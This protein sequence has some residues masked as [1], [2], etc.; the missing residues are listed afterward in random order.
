M[1]KTL[2][3]IFKKSIATIVCTAVGIAAASAAVYAADIGGTIYTGLSKGAA[4]IDVKAYHMTPQA[5]MDEFFKVVDDNP[6]L[7]YVNSHVD[8]KYDMKSGECIELVCSYTTTDVKGTRAKFDAE[9]NKVIAEAKNCKTEY[10]K[11]VAVHDYMVA[12]YEY[13]MTNSVQSA[14]EM[15][16][17]RSGN[18]TCYTGVFK[19]AMDKL[20]I[21]NQVPI[22]K[23]MVH[24][25]N[26]ICIDGQWY[27]A[28]ITWDDPIG[29]QGI[30]YANFLKSDRLMGMTGH[31]NWKTA[32]DIKCT[33]TKYDTLS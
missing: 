28:D 3:N 1:K 10:D 12:N 26:V 32:G 16:T 30:T 14:Y 11:V 9:I 15:L 4:T 24:E 7:F 19:A 18:C 31:I 6:D 22:S 17:G 25:W 27:H 5:A 2:F 8:C 21:K 13:E 33:S 29:G 20:G 23:D